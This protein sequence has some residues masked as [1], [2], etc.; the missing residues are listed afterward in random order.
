VSS[1]GDTIFTGLNIVVT[2]IAVVVAGIAIKVQQYY[3]KKQFDRDAM[4]DVFGMLNNSQHK[5]SE[6]SI[7][8]IF[9]TN[10]LY[11]VGILN[12]AVEES[13][14]TVWRNYDQIGLLVERGLV[15]KNDIFHMFGKIVIVSHWVLF[16]E[17]KRRRL[18]GESDFMTNF[19]HLAID[20]Y[21]YWKNKGKDRL[22][23]EPQGNTVITES[24]INQWKES[25]PK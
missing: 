2:T 22:P 8:D 12:P 4:I 14:T 5:F 13:A 24:S 20:C 21:N 11:N 18:L 3:Q 19:T 23:R 6:N 9:K 25:L 15:P 16:Q 10:N 1:N 7:I 17:L